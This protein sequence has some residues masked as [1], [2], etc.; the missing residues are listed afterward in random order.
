MGYTQEVFQN[1]EEAYIVPN[2]RAAM[3]G[4]LK[5][6]SDGTTICRIAILIEPNFF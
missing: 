2:L 4:N 3:V 1:P 5:R 6:A